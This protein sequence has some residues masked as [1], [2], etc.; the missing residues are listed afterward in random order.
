M[1]E[2]GPHV[3][4]GSR[5]SPG[6]RASQAAARVAARFANAPSYSEMLAAEA[7]AAVIA[8]EAAT[9]AAHKAQA[10]AE[11]VLA[12]LE[13]ASTAELFEGSSEAPGES[14]FRA[15]S[16]DARD[17]HTPA[18][19][20]SAGAS[21]KPPKAEAPRPEDQPFTIR[22]EPDMPVR[23]P[24]TSSVRT[25]HEPETYEVSAGEWS[26]PS[27]QASDIGMVEPA[28]PIYANLIHFPR[29]LVA[30]RKARPRLA[31]GPFAVSAQTS[32]LSIF[33][34][35]PGAISTQPEVEVPVEAIQ[36]PAWNAPEWSG[37]K[38]DEQ[39][40]E[41]YLE[42]PAPPPQL[43]PALEPAPAGRRILAAVV[44]F[45][46]VAGAFQFAAVFAARNVR[47]LPGLREVEVGSAVALMVIG[48]LY[49]MLFFTLAKATPGMKY[50]HISLCTF[51]GHIPTRSQRYARLVALLLSA[52][53]VGLGM[54]WAVFDENHLSWHD[55]LSR[56]YL[57]MS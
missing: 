40:E 42:E 47:S 53:P 44:D 14:S 37:I 21:V 24:E 49:M 25:S 19:E 11:S 12:G 54:M 48:A 26:Q 23:Q 33:E 56:T 57:R 9:R 50:A 18:Q 32:Q 41:E 13:A 1:S 27:A 5:P 7:R 35:D 51:E 31:E 46:L 3:V 55:R 6:N 36:A 38:L 45:T 29:E 16:G 17:H 22:W 4:T 28:Q 10:A 8:A 20:P 30:A 43:E 2:T 52:L 15:V 34:V 39:P